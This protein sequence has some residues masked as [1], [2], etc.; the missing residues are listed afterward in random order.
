MDIDISPATLGNVPVELFR[1]LLQELEIVSTQ[2]LFVLGQ[3]DFL[4]I[5][6]LRNPAQHK[7]FIRKGMAM[8]SV[9]MPPNSS[10][11]PFVCVDGH[12]EISNFL[13]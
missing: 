8:K 2:L 11:E 3:Q 13:K 10:E 4:E 1:D 7:D 12:W 6:R 5:Q 9:F